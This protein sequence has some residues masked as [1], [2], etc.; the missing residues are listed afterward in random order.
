MWMPVM[1]GLEALRQI[2][3]SD[4]SVQVLLMTGQPDMGSLK[5]II[6]NG[7]FDYIVKPFR[8]AEILQTVRNAVEKR[9]L[10]REKR[11]VYPEPQERSA[12]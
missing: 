10:L 6:K 7:A 9:R 8:Q 5:Q 12:E 3:E 11:Q 4:Q 2:K 1:N